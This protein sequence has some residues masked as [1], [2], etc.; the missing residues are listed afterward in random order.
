MP[1]SPVVV[2]LVALVVLAAAV[3]VAQEGPTAT[4]RVGDLPTLRHTAQLQVTAVIGRYQGERRVASTPYSF[5]APVNDAAVPEGK[6]TI[7]RLKMGVEVPIAVSQSE[8]LTSFQYRNVGTNVECNARDEGGGVF[9]LALV[10]ESSSVY[11]ATEAGDEASYEAA[12]A[13]GKPIFRSFYVELNPLLRD[14]QSVETVAST[15][16][17]TGEVV[18]VTVSMKVV[19]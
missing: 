14:G 6:R 8:G 9:G 4:D 19:K 17:V 10:V 13:A 15:D 5:L 16:P 2:S 1:R 3:G 12:A 11:A 7:V 18:K